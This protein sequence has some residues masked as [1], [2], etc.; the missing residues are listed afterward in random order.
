MNDNSNHDVKSEQIESEVKMD[1]ED[2]E[3]SSGAAPLS[4][5]EEEKNDRNNEKI[6]QETIGSED[7][8]KAI[9]NH[10]VKTEQIESEVKMDLEDKEISS[11]A[12]PLSVDVDEKNDRNNEKILQET[13]GSEDATNVSAEKTESETVADQKDIQ[14]GTR[15]V[16]ISDGSSEGEQKA[17]KNISMTVEA[18]VSS[19]KRAFDDTSGFEYGEQ[20]FILRPVKRRGFGI[21]DNM[22]IGRIDKNLGPV[23]TNEEVLPSISKTIDNSASMV[24][25]FDDAEEDNTFDFDSYK[26]SIETASTIR[27]DLVAAI[28]GSSSMSSRNIM[29]NVEKSI[30]NSDLKRR[31]TTTKKLKKKSTEKERTAAVA[32]LDGEIDLLN[33]LPKD[34]CFLL[35]RNCFIFTL[36]Q[37]E[38]VLDDDTNAQDSI[39]R[40]ELRKSLMQTLRKG[41]S[42]AHGTEEKT[43]STKQKDEGDLVSPQ[44]TTSPPSA[45]VDGGTVEISA[46]KENSGNEKDVLEI[47][48]FK[49]WKTMIE[50]W[51]NN[52]GRPS[53]GDQFPIVDG[54][55]SVFF[56]VGT[57]QFMESI[58]VKGLFDFLCLKKTESG[59]AVDMFRAWR[60]KCGLRDISLLPLAKHL[61]GINARIEA[62][63][64]RKFDHEQDF[65]NWVKGPMV[66]LSGAAKDFL[67]DHSKVFSG[68]DF[69]ET[70]TKILADKFC[71][72]RSKNGL[73]ALR[74]SGNVAMV[75][76]WKTQIKDELEI[77]NSKG[78]V[79]P[80]EEIGYEIESLQEAIPDAVGSGFSQR[81][82]KR[83]AMQS[84]SSVDH[85]TSSPSYAALNSPEFFAEYFRDERKLAMFKSVGISTVQDLLDASKGKNSNLLKAL[86]KL[87]SEQ[88]NGKEIQIPSCVSLLYDWAARLK[89][90]AQQMDMGG[91]KSV[92]KAR[93]PEGSRSFR[94]K[95]DSTDPFDA[96][97]KPSKEFLRTSMNIST[98]SVFLD[99]RTTDI[100]NAFVKWRVEKGMAP[101][102]G[103]GAVAS[104]SGWKKLVRTKA[105]A[106]RDS[107]LGNVNDTKTASTKIATNQAQSK[108]QQTK[109]AKPLPDSQLEKL[110]VVADEVKAT[111]STDIK[112]TKYLSVL[113]F[114][115][116]DVFHFELETRNNLSN[117]EETYLRYLGN[118]RQSAANFKGTESIDGEKQCT[119]VNSNRDGKPNRM[120]GRKPYDTSAHGSIELSKSLFDP[121][122]I[123]MDQSDGEFKSL[124]FDCSVNKKSF[125]CKS[126][127]ERYEQILRMVLR[128]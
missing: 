61:T 10:D 74:G 125:S 116:S 100:A 85:D 43:E 40:Q 77:E 17:S 53:D 35:G 109:T 102:K 45:S 118:D 68:T 97:S 80:E 51:K 19:R 99:T 20:D 128:I 112:T 39:L 86:V 58:K 107:N 65:I 110:G 13:I 105:A 126:D 41:S 2:K 27:A 64:K 106:I 92:P 70:K 124:C 31:R 93:K 14:E 76:A 48:K 94:K 1:L 115:K 32:T 103:Q 36:R 88:S 8:T 15:S 34:D 47:P 12:A 90:K 108:P 114:Q 127:L 23:S 57:L 7:A 79:I 5:D 95:S 6:L 26:K 50:T 111:L 91:N 119:V 122:I 38:W 37:L 89:K 69:I 18:R 121:G 46:E 3:I 84:G 82:K 33:I 42:M 67:V 73:S 104:I 52:G 123:A 59:L 113:S 81:I 56:P 54:P 9:S 66:V 62:C 117:G 98:A 96:L 4:V 120:S 49:I 22:R 60:K 25:M 63:L 24:E 72:W 28:L 83:K 87:K 16:P 11:G 55:M 44:A 29:P 21:D 101:L 75:S 78:K 30:N 71:D